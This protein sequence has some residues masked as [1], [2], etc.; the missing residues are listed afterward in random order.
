MLLHMFRA[1]DEGE[2]AFLQQSVQPR[3]TFSLLARTH[4]AEQ[5]RK[6]RPVNEIQ[7]RR[8]F[9]VDLVVLRR[10]VN[11]SLLGDQFQVLVQVVHIPNRVHTASP[12]N[13]FDR[14]GARHIDENQHA[15]H[16]RA[17][18]VR[19]WISFWT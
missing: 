7:R 6:L 5:I 2:I 3:D 13:F 18:S 9:L 15:D 17:E 12:A 14:L 11:V 19:S 4:V 10:M 8:D 16:E 1:V